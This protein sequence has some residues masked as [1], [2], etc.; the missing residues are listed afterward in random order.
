MPVAKEAVTEKVLP[1]FIRRLGFDARDFPFCCGV[2]VVG[3][4]QLVE[5][6]DILLGE[7]ASAEICDL[8]RRCEEAC[9]LTNVNSL[10]AT[11]TKEQG[12]VELLLKATPGWE[13]ARTFTSRG[14]G[15]T[16][17]V[18]TYLCDYPDYREESDDLD[19]D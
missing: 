5:G 11:T 17:T 4:F 6:A 7:V 14:T 3:N 18:W 1:K 15:N 10:V 2:E 8:K 16:I 12:T 13:I 9:D 19:E